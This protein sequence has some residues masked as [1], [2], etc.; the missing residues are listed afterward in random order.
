MT[1]NVC[2]QAFVGLGQH[3]LVEAWELSFPNLG[4]QDDHWSFGV[5]RGEL[6][7]AFE[8]EGL[9]TVGKDRRKKR[10]ERRIWLDF[11][12]KADGSFAGKR[13]PW[14]GESAPVGWSAWRSA[15]GVGGYRAGAV[16]SRAARPAASHAFSPWTLKNAEQPPGGGSLDAIYGS[17]QQTGGLHTHTH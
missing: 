10:R 8:E 3:Q 7:V 17:T 15:R 12:M 14:V 13:A 16:S 5:R 9:G 4:V 2:Q 6:V 1:E 11:H